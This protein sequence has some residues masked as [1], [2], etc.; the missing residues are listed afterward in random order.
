[1]TPDILANRLM[2]Q[3]SEYLKGI[4]AVSRKGYDYAFEIQNT[5]LSRLYRVQDLKR[6]TMKSKRF[7]REFQ[8]LWTITT[9]NGVTDRSMSTCFAG[10]DKEE[11]WNL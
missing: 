5:D 10:T 6:R 8:S 3:F 4:K 9:S 1:M 11:I 7:K 2:D